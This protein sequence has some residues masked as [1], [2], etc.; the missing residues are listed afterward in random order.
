MSISAHKTPYAMDFTC[1]KH[2]V[3][4]TIR[5]ISIKLSYKTM[6]KTV[7]KSYKIKNRATYQH[8]KQNTMHY[9]GG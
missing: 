6:Y 1:I 8:L 5:I 4:R 2:T 9:R 7:Y 3:K